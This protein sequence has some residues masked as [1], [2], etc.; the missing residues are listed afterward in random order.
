VSRETLQKR[1]ELK[2]KLAEIDLNEALKG[3][4][5]EPEITLAKEKFEAQLQEINKEIANS[6]T[7]IDEIKP[8]EFGETADINAGF[9]A[10]LD[11]RFTILQA[12]IDKEEASKAKAREMEKE[13][14]QALNESLKELGQEVY[15]FT[16]GLINQSFENKIAN[17]ESEIEAIQEKA[18]SEI[19]LAE[20]NE[21][22]QAFI[23]EEANR[24]KA[25]LEEKIK[26][27]KLAQFRFDK[28]LR[29]GSIAIDTASGIV[30]TIANLGLPTALPFVVTTAAI[31]AVQLAGVLAQQPP[32]FA[33]GIERVTGKGTET[34]DD[35]W[36]KLSIN[37]RVVKASDNRAIGFDVSN[38]EL[39]KGWR[40]YKRYKN[41]ENQFSNF[42]SETARLVATR[43]EEDAREREAQRQLLAY[44]SKSKE[45]ATEDA[46]RVFAKLQKENNSTT[47]E[48]VEE[49]RKIRRALTVND[50]YKM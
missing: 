20:G 43:Q 19:E 18:D 36:A 42:K 45:E 15:D 38:D 2:K 44:I 50:R 34:S 28:A 30:R 12:S 10:G 17:Y 11:E 5:F 32:Q 46:Y 8:I 47:V 4:K 29:I 1:A 25:E 48:S 27:Q 40:F 6:A 24:K 9:K 13:R 23:Q 3:A 49:L 41:Q 31:G 22:Q 35:V 37:E 26:Q 33:E 14:Q 21:Q 7:Q 16:V 39:V